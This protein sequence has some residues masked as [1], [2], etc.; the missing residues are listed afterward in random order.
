MRRQEVHLGKCSE[1][2]THSPGGES[3]CV[4]KDPEARHEDKAD[5]RRESHWSEPG[6]DHRAKVSQPWWLAAL[7]ALCFQLPSFYFFIFFIFLFIFFFWKSVL[8]L[9]FFFFK[10]N[11]FQSWSNLRLQKSCK[12]ATESGHVPFSQLPQH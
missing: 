4:T 6:T 9:L 7:L 12:K 2:N 1:K 11:D 3:P 8:Y 10:E 5:K